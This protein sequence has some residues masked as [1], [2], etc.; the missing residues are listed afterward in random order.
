MTKILKTF[1]KSFKK[2]KQ[3]KSKLKKFQTD[4]RRDTTLETNCIMITEMKR[5]KEP[6][7]T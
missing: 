1:P 2:N 5:I 6:L 4:Q 3:K 7:L